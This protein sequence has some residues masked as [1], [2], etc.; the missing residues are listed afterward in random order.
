VLWT[1][2]GKKLGWKHR[3]NKKISEFRDEK[4]TRAILQFLGD[5]DIEKIKNGALRPP[6]PVGFLS[7]ASKPHPRPRI[8]L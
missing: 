8:V 4:A 2:I 7:A 5:T 1:T 3:K 6:I